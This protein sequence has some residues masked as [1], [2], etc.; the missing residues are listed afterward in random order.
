MESLASRGIL[1]SFIA[2]INEL[3]AMERMAHTMKKILLF[4]VILSTACTTKPNK[5]H[6]ECIEGN[7]TKGHGKR[8]WDDGGYEKG[9]WVNGKLNGQGVQF[10]GTTSEF[11][12][13]LYEGNFK[14]DQYFGNG[15]YYDKSEDSKYVGQWY[16]GKPEGKGKITWGKRSKTPN[17]YYEGD[18]K[19]G[20]MHGS[21]VK[22]SG[23]NGKYSNNKYVGEFKYGKQEGKGIYY[24]NDGSYYEGAWKNDEQ[25]GSGIYVLKSGE[26]FEGYWVDGYCKELAKK[27]GLE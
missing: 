22:F 7:C 23:I 20:L 24:W 25:N 14:D 2:Y 18:W 21:G 1:A 15:T 26:K 10:F 16:A 17:A 9:Y 12:G 13:D 4:L 19:Y 27:L 11:T 6:W 8:V 3:T 5:N